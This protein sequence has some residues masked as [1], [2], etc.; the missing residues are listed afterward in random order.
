VPAV[1]GPA[2][3]HL[4]TGRWHPGVLLPDELSRAIGDQVLAM[5][6]DGQ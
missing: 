6:H 2:W 5:M 4:G 1:H 3:R